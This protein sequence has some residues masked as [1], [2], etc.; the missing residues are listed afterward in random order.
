[1]VQERKYHKFI[2]TLRSSS[3]QPACLAVMLGALLW[4]TMPA[5]ARA[6][7][8]RYSQWHA[9]QT[10]VN[11]AFAGAYGD[12]R[13]SLNFRD[14]WPDMPQ[15]YISYRAAGDGYLEAIRSGLG[16]SIDQDVQG[17]GL[18][19][20]TQLGMCYMYQARLSHHWALNLGASLDY[21]QFRINWQDVQFYDQISLLTGFNDASGNPNP[22]GEMVP[23]GEFDFMD[24]GIGL[25]LYSDK[26]YAGLSFN[27]VNTPSFSFY[28]SQSS[29]LPGSIGAQAGVF[30]GGKREK[31]L[32]LNPYA[33]WTLQAGFNQLQTGIYLKKSLMLGGLAFKH[34]TAALSDVVI[35]AGLAKGMVRF[36][37]SYDLSTGPLSGLTGGA[38]E[39]SLLLTFRENPGKAQKNSQKSML[40]CPSV[41]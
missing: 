37:Y 6:Q 35:M 28:G 2:A 21:T 34:N 12:L 17:D 7:D 31:D 14:Q 15:S 36:G 19:R 29:S 4:F 41:L 16:V 20:S 40:D 39:V 22:T 1:M 30:L 9:S 32:L 23:A 8:L 13:V 10:S 27:H 38:H 25:L 24:V 5:P 18:L 3:G 11:P 33:L 26:L